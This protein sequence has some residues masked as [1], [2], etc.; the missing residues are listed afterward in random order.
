[1]A[2]SLKAR[3]R[4]KLLRQ[5]HEDGVPDSEHDDPRQ[6]AVAADLEA[7]D[8]VT[9]DDPLLEVLAARYLVPRAHSIGESE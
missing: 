8:A 7:L 2:D 9:E 6:I 5:L 3:I 1:M 4:D